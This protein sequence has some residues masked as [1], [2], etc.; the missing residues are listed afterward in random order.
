MSLTTTF[1]SLVGVFLGFLGVAV[2]FGLVV[3]LPLAVIFGLLTFLSLAAF[4]SFF[5][6]FFPFDLFA[7]LGLARVCFLL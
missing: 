5:V 2:F 6:V 3:F 4:W 7:F 1:F